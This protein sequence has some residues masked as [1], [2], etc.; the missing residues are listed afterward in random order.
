MYTLLSVQKYI[1]ISDHKLTQIYLCCKVFGWYDSKGLARNFEY[2]LYMT[3]YLLTLL[4]DSDIFR[5]ICKALI[6]RAQVGYN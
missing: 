3:L 2:T 1:L 6:E 5:C 4:T